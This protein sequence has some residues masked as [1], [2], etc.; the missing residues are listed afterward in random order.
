MFGRRFSDSMVG[1]WFVALVLDKNHGTWLWYT[2]DIK[3]KYKVNKKYEKYFIQGSDLIHLARRPFLYVLRTAA[4]SRSLPYTLEASTKAV[5][6]L[7]CCRSLS[8]F[9]ATSKTLNWIWIGRFKQIATF[10]GRL[11]WTWLG[12][13][14]WQWGWP[15]NRTWNE[16]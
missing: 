11:E 6:A 9:W 15:R 8:R 10:A 16:D 12:S 5:M 1:S 2:I 4:W 13:C 7:Y 14:K 3:I